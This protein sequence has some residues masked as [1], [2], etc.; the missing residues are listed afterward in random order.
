MG[1][2]L[3]VF[4]FAIY[5]IIIVPLF[6]VSMPKSEILDALVNVDITMYHKIAADQWDFAVD[7]SVLKFFCF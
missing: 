1:G 3:F 7:V 6:Y 4:T 5:P 2:L